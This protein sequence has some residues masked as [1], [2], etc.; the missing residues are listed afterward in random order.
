[1]SRR[2]WSL[3]LRDK[4]CYLRRGQLRGLK[5]GLSQAHLE[6]REKGQSGEEEHEKLV[7]VEAHTGAVELELSLHTH[8]RRIGGEGRGRDGAQVNARPDRHFKVIGIHS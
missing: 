8:T 1:G 4:R 5:R 6:G 7:R 2:F 3:D